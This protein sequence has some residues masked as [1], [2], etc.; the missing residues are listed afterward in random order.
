M[1]LVAKSYYDGSGG[2]DVGRLTLAGYS[3][4]PTAWAEFEARWPSILQGGGKRPPCRALHM[5]E[6][7]RRTGDFKGW[8]PD[9]SLSIQADVLQLMM[10]LATKYDGAISG[11]TCTVDLADLAKAKS[12]CPE[13]QNMNAHELCVRWVVPETFHFLQPHP[14][15]PLSGEAEFELVFDQNE[16]FL[17]QINRLWAVRKTRQ[18]WKLKFV[19][20]I[21]QRDMRQVTPLQAADFL[22]WTTNRYY[23]TRDL[24]VQLMR[25]ITIPIRER[26]LDYSALL[27]EYGQ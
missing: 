7:N 16:D 25:G 2:E 14:P 27:A 12:L 4:T 9:E 19:K 1:A 26:H 24:G 10:V 20:S 6:L 3:A 11:A 15:D 23:A 17:H 13:I 8:T 22:A 18:P 5:T 21:V